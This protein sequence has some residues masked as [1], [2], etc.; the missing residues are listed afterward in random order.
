MTTEEIIEFHALGSCKFEIWCKTMKQI[1]EILQKDARFQNIIF[2]LEES[3]LIDEFPSKAN[4]KLINNSEYETKYIVN[5]LNGM[6][7][8]YGLCSVVFLN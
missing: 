8:K 3:S 7:Q 6:M 1:P 5:L 4:F 2:I